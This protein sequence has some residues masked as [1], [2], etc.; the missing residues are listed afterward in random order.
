MES[1][2][3]H[4]RAR[5]FDGENEK[6]VFK[7]ITIYEAPR[8]RLRLLCVSTPGPSTLKL[9]SIAP[10]G[11]VF[12]VATVLSD[13]SG[14]SVNPWFGEITL[15]GRANGSINTFESVDLIAGGSVNIN[16]GL[17]PLYHEVEFSADRLRHVATR[18]DG[19]VELF[20]AHVSLSFSFQTQSGFRPYHAVGGSDY[21][22]VEERSLSGDNVIISAYHNN[23]GSLNSSYAIDDDVVSL[24]AHDDGVLLFTSGSEG[25]LMLYFDVAQGGVTDLLSLRE[26]LGAL[27]DVARYPANGSD[28]FFVLLYEN[29]TDAVNV[30]NLAQLFPAYQW[31][32]QG[33][34]VDVDEVGGQVLIR[35]NEQLHIYLPGNATPSVSYDL[36]LGAVEIHLFYNK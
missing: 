18:S 27:I 8:E 29:G 17:D 12:P 34:E 30:A 19:K 15:F 24:F 22:F 21:V 25:N 26:D 5:A 10:D 14:A 31:S 6:F 7:E 3:Y 32:I 28:D 9:D 2:S 13:F 33:D 36:P 1:G 35:E 23:S 16:S 4:L 11:Q 20:G